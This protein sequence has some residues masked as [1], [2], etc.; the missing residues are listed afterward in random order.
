MWK[1][2]TVYIT[3]QQLRNSSNWQLPVFFARMNAD[4]CFKRTSKEKGWRPR[5]RY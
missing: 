4:Y 2:K 3:A 5:E 1:A